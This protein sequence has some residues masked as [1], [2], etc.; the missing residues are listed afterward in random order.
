MAGC[1]LPGL[2]ETKIRKMEDTEFK[3]DAADNQFAIKNRKKIWKYEW[4]TDGP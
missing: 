4:F 1:V 2:K 3:S